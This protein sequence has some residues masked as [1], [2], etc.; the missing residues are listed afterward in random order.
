MIYMM[1]YFTAT[2]NCTYE[3]Y[4]I[5]GDIARYN[6]SEDDGDSYISKA[7]NDIETAALFNMDDDEQRLDAIDIVKG[8][9]EDYVEDE[10]KS[11][12]KALEQGRNYNVCNHGNLKECD[13]SCEFDAT[14]VLRRVQK[15]DIEDCTGYSDDIQI[16]ADAI[17][18]ETLLELPMISD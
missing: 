3:K 12:E 2:I 13:K 6:Q 17:K 10:I 8:Y 11:I 1:D 5:I 7:Q 18:H 16:Y 15:S 4:G 9:A 14:L